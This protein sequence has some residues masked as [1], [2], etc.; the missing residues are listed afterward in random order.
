MKAY[1]IDPI[2]K[3]VTVVD[4]PGDDNVKQQLKAM[5]EHLHCS[6]VEAVRFGDDGDAVFVDEEGLLNGAWHRIGGFTFDDPGFRHTVPLAGY[7]LVMGADLETGES[8]D[9]QIALPDLRARLGFPTMD[10]LRLRA[11]RGE[12]D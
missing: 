2:N 7:G 10:E 1:L 3:S 5:Y 6:T 9:A 11:A 4:V 8:R 12:F